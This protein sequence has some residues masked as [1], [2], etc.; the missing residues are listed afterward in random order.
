MAAEILEK[1]FEPFYT[2]KEKDQG[3]GLGLSIVHGIVKQHNGAITAAS[4]KNC[5]TTFTIL[6]PCTDAPVP[7]AAAQP[8]VLPIRGG[9]ETILLAED[10]EAVR[11][12]FQEILT[13]HGYKIIMAMDGPDAVA[14][15]TRHRDRIKLVI[16]D[17]IMPGQNGG[18]VLAAIRR[19]SPGLK[20]LFVSGYSAEV[21]E[22]TGLIQ[23]DADFL[24][25][26]ILPN[27]FLQRI[28][29][30]LDRAA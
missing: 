20:A 30:I 24:A 19:M 7:C 13:S 14:K 17:A 18:E 5:G 25:K 23:Q 1:I 27:E 16:L 21:V 2:T 6:I 12:L 10:E 11:N 28:R 4:E 9:A 29:E 15:F 26:P 8:E 22:R 3:T